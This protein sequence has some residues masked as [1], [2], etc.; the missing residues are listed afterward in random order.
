MHGQA[1]LLRATRAD[2][3]G[4][5]S[6]AGPRRK[7]Y[8]AALQQFD[9]LMAA[10]AAIGPVSRPLPLYYAILQAG[11]AIAAAWV[12][13]DE[14]SA[15]GHGLMEDH[16]VEWHSDILRFR[17]KPSVAGRWGPGVFGVVAA[18][19]GTARLTGSAEL[20]ALWSALPQA[21]PPPKAG[22]WPRALAIQPVYFE[23]GRNRTVR[24]RSGRVYLPMRATADDVDS[25]R[26]LLATYP[27]AASASVESRDVEPWQNTEGGWGIAVGVTWPEPSPE[28]VPPYPHARRG[29]F[30]EGEHWLVPAV[31][32]GANRLPPLLLWW[33]LLFGL[34]LLARYYPAQWRDALD[35]DQ[36]PYAHWLMELLDEALAIVPA[37]LYEAAANE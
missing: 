10:A 15:G 34:S 9:D 19:I 37:L 35:L 31:V 6:T 11:K 16:A 23:R 1:N 2:P 7:T 12:P 26:Q 29:Q 36:S 13:G 20:G 28:L 17:V 3:P 4:R 5:A 33:I 14:W 25:V 21:N 24:M 18:K 8:S 22:P 30:P 27:D 32:T